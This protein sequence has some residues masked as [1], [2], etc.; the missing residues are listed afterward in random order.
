MQQRSLRDNLSQCIIFIV[1]ALWNCS[2]SKLMIR[3]GEVSNRATQLRC[4]MSNCLVPVVAD[5]QPLLP[6]A[7]RNKTERNT[8]VIFNADW[9]VLV[10]LSPVKNGV[11]G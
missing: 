1:P 4:A 2:E 3:A 11:L 6:S 7:I 10:S 9:F 5:P 8:A